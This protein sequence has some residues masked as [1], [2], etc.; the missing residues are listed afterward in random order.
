MNLLKRI[1]FSDN[2]GCCL[3]VTDA[4]MNDIIESNLLIVAAKRND[5][6]TSPTLEMICIVSSSIPGI[7]NVIVMLPQKL[8]L[9]TSIE[10]PI[11]NL[12]NWIN[13]SEYPFLFSPFFHCIGISSG[14]PRV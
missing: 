7:F 10:P 1:K 12:F 4:F 13:Q 2:Y 8:L 9:I 6:H 5:M 3:F 14:W 11:E